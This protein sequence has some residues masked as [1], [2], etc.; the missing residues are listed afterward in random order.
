VGP[1]WRHGLCGSI[2]TETLGGEGGVDGCPDLQAQI[3][4]FEQMAKT[5]DG[6]FVGKMI[7]AIASRA[8]SRNIGVAYIAFSMVGSDKLNHRRKKWMR[9]IV[10]TATVDAHL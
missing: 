8:N 5:Q 2:N 10:S 9:S 1:G 3:V 7:H 4:S 6:A